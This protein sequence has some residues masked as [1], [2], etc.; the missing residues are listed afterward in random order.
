MRNGVGT[1]HSAAAWPCTADG[2]GD[3]AGALNRRFAASENGAPGAV[4]G[5]HVG[6][7]IDERSEDSAIAVVRRHVQRGGAI[8]V[9]GGAGG[10]GVGPTGVPQYPTGTRNT[11]QQTRPEVDYM[12]CFG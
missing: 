10:A 2:G 8:A 9:H 6:V 5:V 3:S 7:G 1:R 12:F 4:L 11:K